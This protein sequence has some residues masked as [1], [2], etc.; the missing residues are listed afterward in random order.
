MQ[1]DP[2]PHG[3]AEKAIWWV[4]SRGCKNNVKSILYFTERVVIM[5]QY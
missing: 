4:P 1:S 3:D 5:G 2:M